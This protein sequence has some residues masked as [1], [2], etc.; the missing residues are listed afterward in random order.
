M[1][2][3]FVLKFF[4]RPPSRSYHSELSETARY[5]G[6]GDPAEMRKTPKTKIKQRANEKDEDV[7]DD[8]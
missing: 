6:G 5:D 4:L 7:S 3:S 2:L 1:F 8:D